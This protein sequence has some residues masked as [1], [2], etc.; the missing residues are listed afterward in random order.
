MTPTP[1]PYPYDPDDDTPTA[2]TIRFSGEAAAAAENAIHA[3]CGWVVRVTPSEEDPTPRRLSRDVRV[4][5][6]GPRG[7]QFHGSILCYDVDDDGKRIGPDY[8]IAVGDLYVD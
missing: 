8:V 2:I 5:A 6:A 1:S 4:V 7:Q 3:M